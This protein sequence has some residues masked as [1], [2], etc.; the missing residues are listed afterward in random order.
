MSTKIIAD[1]CNAHEGERF[2]M[3]KMIE[4]TA[5][6]GCDYVKFQLFDAEKLNKKWENYEQ[7]YE[8]YKKCQLSDDDIE[9]IL[10]YCI[11]NEIKALFTAFDINQ[12][13]RLNRFTCGR[14][15]I[16]SPDCNNWDLIGYCTRNYEVVFIS[17]GMHTGVE[18][19][20]IFSKGYTIIPMFCRS[21]YPVEYYWHESDKKAMEYLKNNFDLWGISDHSETVSNAIQ[22]VDELQPDYIER[23]F[24]LEKTGKKDDIVSS[25]PEDMARLTNYPFPELSEEEIK[26]RKYITRWR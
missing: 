9:F 14:I 21:V 13:K 18:I 20:K 26:N 12:A 5:R 16:A 4:E 23:H 6:I 7:A 25:T 10:H 8:H 22:I 3:G 2:L 1:C 15:K 17:L 24:T 11:T 19:K